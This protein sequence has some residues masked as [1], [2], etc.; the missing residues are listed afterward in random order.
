M[1]FG[2]FLTPSN[3]VID[4]SYLA[5]AIPL[6]APEASVNA[7]GVFELLHSYVRR[8]REPFFIGGVPYR[9]YLSLFPEA[10]TDFWNSQELVLTSRR[11]SAYAR[12]VAVTD[13]PSVVDAGP[14]DGPGW[15]RSS[16]PVLHIPDFG[17]SDKYV[18]FLLP[19]ASALDPHPP[20]IAPEPEIVMLSAEGSPNLVGQFPQGQL[21]FDGLGAVFHSYSSVDALPHGDYSGED[22]IVLPERDDIQYFEPPFPWPDG[23]VGFT[24]Y[25]G[26]YAG[27][28]TPHPPP[29]GFRLPENPI[30]AA[31]IQA[32][33][34]SQSQRITLPAAFGDPNASHMLWFA[35]PVAETVEG[36]WYDWPD[37]YYRTPAE[38]A[39]EVAEQFQVLP[40][41]VQPQDVDVG[42]VMYRVW[43]LSHNRNV[44]HRIDTPGLSMWSLWA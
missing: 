34:M 30:D 2:N 20:I 18:H 39:A 8:I 17:G 22:L 42:G 13:T 38:I 25:A 44:W 3:F 6:E 9:L 21:V 23:D 29:G 16:D 40:W 24:W 19:T 12:Y 14:V 10:F 35:H 37:P 41:R 1:S 15:V 27:D 5:L 4:G 33:S 32:A 43:L 36:V 11:I 31:A 26:H 7:G 28:F